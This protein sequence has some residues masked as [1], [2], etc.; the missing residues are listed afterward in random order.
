MRMG[1]IGGHITHF[2]T[3]RF[4]PGRHFA[5]SRHVSETTLCCL[6]SEEMTPTRRVRRKDDRKATTEETNRHPLEMAR[7]FRDVPLIPGKE[8]GSTRY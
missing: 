6:D 1:K 2:R 5:R 4:L 7:A 3:L 8:R